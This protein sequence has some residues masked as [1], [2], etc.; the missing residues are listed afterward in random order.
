MSVSDQI[1]DAER[2]P[3]LLVA[4]D[5]GAMSEG[6]LHMA[7]RSAHDLRGRILV[8]Y[9]VLR[10]SQVPLDMP[11]SAHENSQ[12]DLLQVRAEEIAA[13]HGVRCEFAV[14]QARS[15]GAAV[16]AEARQHQARMIFIGLRERR[17]PGA[18]V[19]ISAT[20]RHVL[21]HAPCPVQI[22]YLPANLPE[23]SALADDLPEG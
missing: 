23:G 19:L 6:Q 17:R 21:Q 4:Y 11:L 1:Q 12:L 9:V 14:A 10:P 15:V 18:T 7:C 20:V 2:A 13:H 22:G 16:I 5:G 3:V 8:L